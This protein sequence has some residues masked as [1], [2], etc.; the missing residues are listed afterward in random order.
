MKI[1]IKQI[2]VLF[3]SLPSYRYF[4]KMNICKQIV[5]TLFVVIQK[6]TTE[7][8]TPQFFPQLVYIPVNEQIYHLIHLR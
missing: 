5:N 2:K 7:Q 1:R 4:L 3:A 6:L 8:L